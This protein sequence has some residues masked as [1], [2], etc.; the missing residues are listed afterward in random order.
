MQPKDRARALFLKKMIDKLTILISRLLYFTKWI[1][2]CLSAIPLAV[3]SKCDHFQI[4]FSHSFYFY[5]D[6]KLVGFTFLINEQFAA[7]CVPLG[8]AG[9]SETPVPRPTSWHKL[10][11][12]FKR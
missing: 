12:L 11:K 4:F 10:T 7:P 3:L 1:F 8:A 9:S 5:N 6:R 2:H